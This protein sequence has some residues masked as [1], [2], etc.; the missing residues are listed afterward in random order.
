MER[1]DE[2]ELCIEKRLIS[3]VKEYPC[4]YAKG[5]IA[6]RNSGARVKA[7]LLISKT[8]NISEGIARTKWRNL[9]DRYV[10][11]RRKQDQTAVSGAG[12]EDVYVS[13]WIFF[14]EL[15]FLSAHCE[16]RTTSGN[17]TPSESQLS[18]HTKTVENNKLKASQQS[19]LPDTSRNIPSNE[20]MQLTQPRTSQSYMAARS[21]IQPRASS[22]QDG[23]FD[24]TDGRQ[25][26]EEE[27]G[28]TPSHQTYHQAASERPGLMTE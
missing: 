2:Y 26:D 24:N 28:A 27:F 10:K 17:Y 25:D 6:Y 9:K 13:K 15:S 21:P 5:T 3:L 19:V 1:E 23:F 7:W 11:E 22:S 20:D 8:L 18:V 12:S 4:I 14:N 16:L